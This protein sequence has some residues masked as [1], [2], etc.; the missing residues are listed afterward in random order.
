MKLAAGL[1]LR[2]PSKIDKVGIVAVPANSGGIVL[3]RGDVTGVNLK[4]LSRNSDD[5]YVGG[6]DTRP[7]SGYG[8]CLEPGESLQIDISKLEG[9][10]VVSMISG[11]AVTYASV[12]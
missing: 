7:Y 4:A 5:I 10:C 9:I 1:S 3:A 12:R 2:I 8:Y 11:D 6:P